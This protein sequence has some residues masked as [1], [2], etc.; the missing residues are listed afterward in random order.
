MMGV[1]VTISMSAPQQSFAQV[2]NLGAKT[3]MSKLN[4]SI[5]LD[6]KL[7]RVNGNE[8]ALT[9]EVLGGVR[10]YNYTWSTGSKMN[11][12]N[13]LS[14]GMYSVTVTDAIGS[15]FTAGA[16]VDGFNCEA[17]SC[18]F[19]TQTQGGWGAV[20]NGNNPGVYLHAN[21]AGAFP[22]GLVV[23]CNYT[24]T[25][26]SAQAVTDFLPSGSVPSALT[27]NLVDPAGGYNNVLAGQVVA[28]SLSIG[29]D[30]YDAAFST[31][32]ASLGDLEIASGDFAGFTVQELLDEANSF[33]GGCASAYTASQLN[34]ALTAVNEN[35]VDGT[36]NNGYVLCPEA[37]TLE[38]SVNATGETCIDLCNGTAEAVVLGG[39]MPYAYLWSNGETTSSIAGL[40]A[41]N[42]EVTVTDALGCEVVANGDV[43][44]SQNV[45]LASITKTDVTCNGENDGSIVITIDQGTGPFSYDWTPAIS[46]SASANYLAP[47]LYQI[48]IE[49][50]NGCATDVQ[51]EILEPEVLLAGVT[52]VDATCQNADG[53]AHVD[54]SGGTEP[55]AYLWSP[56]GETTADIYNLAAGQYSVLVTDA[57]GCTASAN[58]SIQGS[59]IQL[60]SSQQDATCPGMDDGSATV[61]PSGGAEPYTYMWSPSGGTMASASNLTAGVYTVTVTDDQ[62]CVAIINIEIANINPICNTRF[63]N[64]SNTAQELSVYP[65]IISNDV[66]IFSSGTESVNASVTITSL[67]G[68]VA[69]N[70]VISLKPQ[71]ETSLNTS[72]FAPGIYSMSI[73]TELQNQVFRIVKK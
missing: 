7:S 9:V 42:Y 58:L 40:C 63:S 38:V 37:S 25:L 44:P 66:K 19:R 33:L 22:S 70:G 71:V 48:H 21:F 5:H 59:S 10:P 2:W 60:Q 53:S 68:K 50:G 47:G 14:A 49:D 6:H 41:A 29:F 35:F 69:F 24:L 27:A 55:Y 64:M 39:E 72:D 16:Q 57:N 54:A 4:A 51:E 43:D 61:F 1:A 45:L 15:R 12:V 62:G 52:S 23:G 18:E 56:S 28:L 36:Q 13:G 65:S 3:K 46:N 30:N 34:D 32:P 26:S 73:N 67:D 8:G 17:A 11:Y 31:S 20:P